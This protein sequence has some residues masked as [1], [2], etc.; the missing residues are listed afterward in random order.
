MSKTSCLGNIES[1]LKLLT[2]TEKKVADYILAH[3]R[4]TLEYTVTELAEHADVSDATVV[5]FCRSVGYKGYQDL[6]IKLAQDAIAPRKHLNTVLDEADTPEQI[7]EKIIRSEIRVLEETMNILDMKELEA[8]AEAIRTARKVYFFGSGGSIL[9]AQDAMHKFLK[10]G[11]QS[12][13]QMDVDIQ[14]MESAL[15]EKGDVAIGI[16]HSGTNRNVIECLKNARANGATTIAL[17]TYGKSPIQKHCDYLLMTSTQE[18]VF[19]SESLTA[20][21]AQL[22]VIDSLT[23][24]MSFMDYDKA[25]E[26]IQKTRSATSGRKY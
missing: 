26:A 6:K 17:T 3:S 10:I 22:A 24:V 5:R 21:I 1:K 20:R 12:I 2:N 14:A 8:A 7:T 13:V 25:Y 16:S 9:V 15:L 18:T 19:K 4:E 23:A 11:V